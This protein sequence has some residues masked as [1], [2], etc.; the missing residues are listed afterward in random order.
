MPTSE[1]DLNQLKQDLV[2]LAKAQ[3]FD[4]VRVTH[5]DL[6]Q[7]RA[8]VKR[9]LRKGFH[10]DMHYL[11]RNLE[12]R[13]DPDQLVP[14][15]LSVI[16]VR[17]N[18]L[19]TDTQPIRVL[20]NPRQAYI[21]RYSLG[22][23]Y[24]KLMRRKLARLA[25]DLHQLSPARAFV[26]SAPVLEKAL[27]EQAGL[28]WIGKNTLLLNRKAGSWFF[29][30]E[31]YT[32]VALPPD[33]PVSAHCGSCR[34]CLECCPTQAI[35][36][37]YQLDARKCIAYLTIENRGPIPEA[38]RPK[39]GNR[40]FGCDDCQLVCPWNKYAKTTQIKDFEPRNG[41]ASA[42]LLPLFQW[43]EAEYVQRTQGSALA[44]AGYLGWQ[45]NLAVALGNAPYDPEIC[46]V[47]AEKQYPDLV[48]QHVDW[49][50]AQQRRR[51]VESS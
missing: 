6:S 15:T 40:I 23:D 1:T 16:S 48:Q 14:G 45:R 43:S 37:P 17:L 33:P 12:K 29:L 9:W 8:H 13:L 36:A 19:P 21:A 27:A 35:V 10:A 41:L 22:R 46:R 3:G 47:L 30:G 50:L 18:Y 26:D 39:L 31:L 2:T 51:A 4:E 42:E 7:Y 44:R 38:L 11:E 20:N 49:A 34:A 5:V 32:N 28:G 25:K 24:H